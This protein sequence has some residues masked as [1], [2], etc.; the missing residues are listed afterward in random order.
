[1]TTCVHF[2]NQHHLDP[3]CDPSAGSA[4]VARMHAARVG[5]VPARLTR[6]MAALDHSIP[7]PAAMETHSCLCCS[8]FGELALLYD[9]PRAATVRATTKCKLWVM[10]R[11]VYNTIYHQDI[12]DVR[13]A[14]LALVKSMPIFKALSGTLQGT[15]CDALQHCEHRANSALFYK[16]DEGHLFYLIKQ[17]TVEIT[18]GDKARPSPPHAVRVHVAVQRQGGSCG[19]RVAERP[20]PTALESSGADVQRTGFGEVGPSA[21]RLTLAG[22]G[23]LRAL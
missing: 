8:Y 14:K 4:T 19:T 6:A 22:P 23:L 17:G 18:I 10:E 9:Q 11:S 13:N 1:M 7:R 2:G 3:G 20:R 12:R 21:L 5:I 15:L 16:G